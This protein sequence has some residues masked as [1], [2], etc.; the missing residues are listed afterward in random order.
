MRQNIRLVTCPLFGHPVVYKFA[1]FPWQTSMIE[2]GTTAYSWING[3]AI[4]PQFLGHVTEAGRVIGFLLEY[5]PGHTAEVEDLEKCQRSLKSL[6]ALGIKHC[7]V[8]KHNFLIRGGKGE[9]GLIDFEAT[10]RCQD[11][12]EPLEEF[13]GLREQLEQSDG[14]GGIAEVE[15]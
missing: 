5:I 12:K 2:M 8:N 4:A 9:A 13:E 6:H 1:E 3:H 11:E 14:K 7:D 15:D 10:V